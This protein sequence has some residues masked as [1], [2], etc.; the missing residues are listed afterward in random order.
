[1]SSIGFEI[2]L[3]IGNTSTELLDVSQE[4]L[5]TIALTVNLIPKLITSITTPI[6]L[7]LYVTINQK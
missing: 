4:L 7:K 2:T 3:D 6:T 5:L 1:M